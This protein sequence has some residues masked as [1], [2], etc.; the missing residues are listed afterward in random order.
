MIG[1]EEKLTGIAE[2]QLVFDVLLMSAHRACA[3]V[4]QAANFFGRKALA[5][6]AEHDAFTG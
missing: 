2:A 3:N 4:E 1:G 6:F 5:D